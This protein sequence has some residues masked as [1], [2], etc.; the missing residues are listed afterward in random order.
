[1]QKGL[2]YYMNRAFFF[3]NKLKPPCKWKSYKKAQKPKPS[4][5][6]ERSFIPSGL[7]IVMVVAFG[8]SSWM[9]EAFAS[10]NRANISSASMRPSGMIRI[11][12]SRLWPDMLPGGKVS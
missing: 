3:F 11:I 8:G 9:M 5:Q 4:L 2:K 10:R 6:Y 7:V 1:M 12:F